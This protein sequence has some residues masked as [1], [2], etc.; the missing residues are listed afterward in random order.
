MHWPWFPKEVRLLETDGG[1]KGVMKH[2][3]HVA[4]R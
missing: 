1:E 2:G 3:N 4:W